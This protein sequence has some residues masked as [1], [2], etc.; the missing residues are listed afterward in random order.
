MPIP[1]IR[2]SLLVVLV[3]GLLAGCGTKELPSD[4]TPEDR[5]LVQ[6]V[7][8]WT[9]PEALGFGD[10]QA[11]SIDRGFTQGSGLRAERTGSRTSRQAYQF[12]FYDGEQEVGWVRCQSEARRLTGIAGVTD[13]AP[14]AEVTLD[15]RGDPD[16][17]EAEWRLSLRSSGDRPV[18]GPVSAGPL[19]YS[20]RAASRGGPWV[21]SG[22]R[23]YQIQSSERILAM[24]EVVRGGMVWIEADL[25]R[26]AR[27]VM[28]M[29]A[30]ALLLYEEPPPAR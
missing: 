22:G 19:E 15:C 7:G 26:R 27:R 29:A 10:Y 17:L 21:P 20:V 4:L 9:T 30:V 12:L 3:P 18:Q 25:S 11:R 13:I 2:H 24:V 8:G 23:G 1:A 14:G 28:A 6:G 5:L 16:G